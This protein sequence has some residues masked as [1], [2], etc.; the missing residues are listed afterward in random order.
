MPPQS[1]RAQSPT[2]TTRTSSPYFSPNSAIAPDFDRLRLRHHLGLH[3]QVGQHQ[4]VDPR[5]DV[6]STDA[7]HRAG[8]G[9]VEPEPARGVLRARLGGGVTE[10][11]A[12][13][14][15]HHVGRRVRAA[16][17]AA[18]L[19][20]DDRPAPCAPTVTSPDSTFAWCTI[21]PGDRRLHVEHLDPGTVAELDHALV[22][23]LTAALGVERRAV[24]HELDLV[25]LGEPTGRDAVAADDAANRRL[26]DDLVVAG[27]L[28]RR[29]DRVRDLAV[30]AASA[31]LALLRPRVGL[32]PV[33]LLAHQPAEAVL[34][35]RQP[36]LGGHLQGQV[37]REA[38]GVVQR[39]RLVAGQ[40]AAPPPA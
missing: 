29:A 13:R 6:A 10:R 5:L 27:E 8:R 22:G 20:V 1:S 9:E 18:A 11:L 4:V 26:A 15:V 24:E 21:R 36:L 16:D 3:R 2:E 35:D 31:C 33:A 19:D 17:R 39:E 12:E 38:V 28:H 23:E 30:G 25:A 7:R 14:L 34:V 37:D 32:G 40:L